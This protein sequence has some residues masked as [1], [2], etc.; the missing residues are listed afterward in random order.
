MTCVYILSS[1]VSFFSHFDTAARSHFFTF[2]KPNS[3]VSP[4][5][6]SSAST[7]GTSRLK[8]TLADRRSVTV[9]PVTSSELMR[10]GIVSI[11]NFF[12]SEQQLVCEL[13][14]YVVRAASPCGSFVSSI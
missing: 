2:P 12:S 5:N 1:A 7:G 4:V 6:R 13:A 10:H 8:V 14:R 11:F 3:L 9:H